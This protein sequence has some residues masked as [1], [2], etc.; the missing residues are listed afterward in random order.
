M[1]T[2]IIRDEDESELLRVQ[3]KAVDPAK[4]TIVIL[5]ALSKIEPAKKKRSDAGH[6]RA[7]R[8]DL[9]KTANGTA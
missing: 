6:K 2:L 7:P 5:E 3:I 1:P 4:A 8:L 9:P